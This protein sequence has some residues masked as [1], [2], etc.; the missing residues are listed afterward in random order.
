LNQ[1]IFALSKQILEFGEIM[2][3][4]P[5]FL[6]V[7]LFT[8]L[9]PFAQCRDRRVGL[10]DRGIDRGALRRRSPP[11]RSRRASNGGSEGM[12]RPDPMIGFA[13][14]DAHDFHFF[15]PAFR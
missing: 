7:K 14:L 8:Y 11:L 3:F 1:H 6:V 12:A 2:K 10:M 9:D 5:Q 15:A 4:R 13:E